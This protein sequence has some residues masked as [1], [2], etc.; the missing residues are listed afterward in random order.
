MRHLLVLSFVIFLYTS[1]SGQQ[2][3]P[4]KIV[5]K[6]NYEEVKWFKTKGKGT[7]KGIAK[8]KSKNGVLRFGK[9]FRI[10]LMPTS[11]Y[12]EERLYHIYKN[13]KSGFVYIEDSVPKFI[14]DPKGY[15][16][17]KKI[18][19]NEAGEFEFNQL[20]VGDYYIVAFMLWDKTGGGL[21]QRVSLSANESKVVE[22]KNF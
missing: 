11:L 14:P 17:T 13:K 16:D 5:N 1:G 9:E 21:M 12:T 10:E 8:F 6:F 22:M 2:K 19:C 3:T 7:I 20:P 18:M 4:I 15:H